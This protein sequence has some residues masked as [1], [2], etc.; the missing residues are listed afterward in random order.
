MNY[1]KNFYRLIFFSSF[2]FLV[3]STFSQKNMPFDYTKIE[4][5]D[6]IT[7][8]LIFEKEIDYIDIGAAEFSVDKLKNIVK[9]KYTGTDEWDINR[10][11]NLTIVTK[12][13]N[14]Y[15][16]WVSYKKLL[17]KKTHICKPKDSYKLDSFDV[18]NKEKIE[19]KRCENLF[20]RNSNVLKKYSKHKMMYQINGIF[21]END[22]IIL[23]LKIE[24]QSNINFTTDSI[25]FLLTTKEKF[26]PLKSLKKLKAV[27]F[28]EKSA[29][30]TCNITKDIAAKSSRTILFGFNRFVPTNNELL[31]VRIAES[32][33]GGR[34]GKI[35][36]KIDD[37]LLKK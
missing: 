23:R 13:G 8:H 2:L 6:K 9:I 5:S 4:V 31:E 1:I 24:N 30:F 12:G 14:Y 21:Y 19:A 10:R 34:R 25:R 18:L 26:K 37:F 16:F 32:N 29:S 17:A 35:V 33:S 22:K 36:L 7:T 27:Q 20:S 15:S 28:I 3:T 11:T